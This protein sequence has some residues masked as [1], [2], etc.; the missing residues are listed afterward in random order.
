M[1]SR[2]SGGIPSI[3]GWYRAAG[4]FLYPNVIFLEMWFSSTSPP[5]PQ[6]EVM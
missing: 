5:Q 2:A 4:Q 6:Q 1:L 3:E